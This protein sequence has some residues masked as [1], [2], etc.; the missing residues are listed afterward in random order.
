M[1]EN[2][3]VTDRQIDY[4]GRFKIETGKFTDSGGGGY[5]ITTKV[6]QIVWWKLRAV[7]SGDLAG[8]LHPNSNDGTAGTEKGSLYIES[9]LAS[10]EEYGYMVVGMGG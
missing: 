5:H 4:E 1:A 3:T 2:T 6:G 10:G 8:L 7:E 9:D